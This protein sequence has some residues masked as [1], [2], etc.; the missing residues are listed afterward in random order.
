METNIEINWLDDDF[1]EDLR[2][3]VERYL[4]KDR[5]GKSLETDLEDINDWLSSYD[6][7]D[8]C[9]G[10]PNKVKFRIRVS[11][12]R[13]VELE[14]DNLYITANLQSPYAVFLP[15]EFKDDEYYIVR[16]DK[17]SSEIEVDVAGLQQASLIGSI[18]EE[19]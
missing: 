11:E 14:P 8:E 16:T 9:W 3:S 10:C 19:I 17:D 7:I 12:V 15:P 13:E 6:D 4:L 5:Y 1:E 18:N 2:D